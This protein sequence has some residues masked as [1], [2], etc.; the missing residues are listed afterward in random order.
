MNDLYLTKTETTTDSD[1]RK[2]N[3]QIVSTLKSELQ[4]EK[5]KSSHRKEQD[6]NTLISSF[7]D[8]ISSKIDA[9][10]HKINDDEFHDFKVDFLKVLTTLQ[11]VVKT[12]NEQK[13]EISDLKKEVVRLTESSSKA[14][15][16]SDTG[17]VTN[18]TTDFTNTSNS[19][20]PPNKFK[21]RAV[22]AQH[23]SPGSGTTTSRSVGIYKKK[24]PFS[25]TPSR[26]GITTTT[27]PISTSIQT[28][29]VTNTETPISSSVNTT[30]SGKSVY[31]RN[32]KE[33]NQ[34]LNDMSKGFNQAIGNVNRSMA[35]M[36][37]G[38]GRIIH[39]G[40]FR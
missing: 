27:G 24:Y 39:R 40:A 15:T 34:K 25:T 4:S 36:Y 2:N 17:T 14:P 16:S 7:G 28:R 8:E 33:Y 32:M 13:E 29:V 22:I 11:S 18:S 9:T 19:S 6:I 3:A 10:I 26:P 38:K 31:A 35:A 1:F 12:I 5:S 21:N 37:T 20:I 30:T 23:K